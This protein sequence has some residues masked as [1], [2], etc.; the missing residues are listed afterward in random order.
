M[1]IDSSR[2]S[3]SATG[4]RAGSLPLLAGHDLEVPLATGETRRYINLDYA[5][6]TPAMERVVDTVLSLLPWYS[7]VHR[8]A[9]FA[10]QVS[11]RAYEAA[12]V[13]VGQFVGARSTDAV[14]FVRNTTE[15]INLLAHCL[16][17]RPEQVVL[18]T[19][20]EHHANMLPWR[21][22]AKVVSLDA[23]DS[24]G[25]LVDS[26]RKALEDRGRPVGLVAITGASN[27]TGEVFPIT[28][29]A[30][31]AHEHGAMVAVDA[32]QLAPHRAIDMIAMGIDCLALSGHKMY[33][34]FGAGALVAP[35]VV[36]K[37]AEPMLVGGGA[38]TYVTL[39][40]VQ[41]G[42]LPDRLEAGSPNVVGAV[43]L[44]AAAT[45]LTETGL[46]HVAAHERRLLSYL[47]GQLDELPHIKRLR[48]WNGPQVDRLGVATFTID[49]MHHA[50]AAA[51]L[52]A[53][54]AIGVRHGC[55]CA[56]PYITH[57]LGVSIGEAHTIRER[58]R[59]GE[60]QD[61]P[62]A[63]RASFG[64]GTTV[65]HI[66]RLVLALREISERGPRLS[67]VEDP[68]SGDY[69]PQE[70]RRAFPAFDLLP[71]LHTVGHAPGCG[72]F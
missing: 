38:V 51:V 37:A 19:I 71:P 40:D 17:L 46:D 55:F 49:G 12:R 4:G 32:A 45:A 59:R 28:E 41:W 10:S 2:R 6:S 26:V 27:V 16:N 8:G 47:D 33:A 54:Y 70:D 56:H 13:A 18:S 29:I 14:I 61:I 63:V 65:E 48:L 67:Y 20:I 60:H 36:V 66:D 69:L 72:Q 57:L 53:E 52:S 31:L 24:P 25:E 35:S 1:A 15:A 58:L 68:D 11:T 9:G 62:G 64:L 43:A 42:P 23:P 5:A 3:R 39:D 21:R 34:P 30:R 50:L 44:G 22:L 7:S